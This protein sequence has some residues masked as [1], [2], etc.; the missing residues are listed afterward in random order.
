MA[1]MRSVEFL[2]A[3]VDGSVGR[4]SEG[5]VSLQVRQ[6]YL[7]AGRAKERSTD[8]EIKEIRVTPPGCPSAVHTCKSTWKASLPFHHP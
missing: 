2:K 8:K 6:G 1:T 5:A 7:V 3:S 4:S